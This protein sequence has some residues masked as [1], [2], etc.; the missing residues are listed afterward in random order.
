MIVSIN[1]RSI[2][3]PDMTKNMI[4]SPRNSTISTPGM[5][6]IF[7]LKTYAKMLKYCNKT[8]QERNNDEIKENRVRWSS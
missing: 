1:I 4:V 5:E 8:E 6:K 7:T 2:S 3:I